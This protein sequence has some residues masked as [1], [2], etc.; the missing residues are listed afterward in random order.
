MQPAVKPKDKPKNVFKDKSPRARES[1]HN[2]FLR[3]GSRHESSAND[4]P[5][6]RRKVLV[7]QAEKRQN[8]V[9]Q[10]TANRLENRKDRVAHPTPSVSNSSASRL[11]QEARDK[12]ART[13]VRGAPDAGLDTIILSQRT[14]SVPPDASEIDRSYTVVTAMKSSPRQTGSTGDKGKESKFLQHRG[15]GAGFNQ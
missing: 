14:S 6:L 9:A 8:A 10:F 13:V 12:H 5:I 3:S 11:E 4:L 15:Y 2:A 7:T 1:Y